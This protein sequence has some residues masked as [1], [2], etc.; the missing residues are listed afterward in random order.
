MGKSRGKSQT[1]YNLKINFEYLAGFSH[2]VEEPLVA[3][4]CY[5]LGGLLSL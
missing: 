4:N 3:F 5:S 1:F 2:C